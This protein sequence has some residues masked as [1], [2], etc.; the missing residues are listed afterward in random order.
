MVKDIRSGSSSSPTRL[1][2]AG[3]NTIYFSANDGT[4]GEELWKSDGTSSL[5]VMVKDIKAEARAAIS[6]DAILDIHWR[7]PLFRADDGTNGVN[8]GRAMERPQAR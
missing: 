6:S 2:A 3:G 7:Y 4:N 5:T 8:C 1:T